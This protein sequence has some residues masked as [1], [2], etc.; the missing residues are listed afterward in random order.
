[1]YIKHVA[2]NILLLLRIPH[3]TFKHLENNVYWL[4]TVL[5]VTVLFQQN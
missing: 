1:M 4:K 3:S 2:N 5:V